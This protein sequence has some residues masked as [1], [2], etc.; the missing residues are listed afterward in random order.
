MKKLHNEVHW[1]LTRS[2]AADRYCQK[3][4]TRIDGPWTFGIKPLNR[5]N[6]ADWDKIRDLAKQGKMEEVPADVY[7]KCYR[8]LKNIQDDH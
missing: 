7:V 8:T 1:E 2:K 4:D 5:A 6:A 3:S